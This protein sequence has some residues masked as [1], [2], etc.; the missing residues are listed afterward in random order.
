MRCFKFSSPRQKIHLVFLSWPPFQD[1]SPWRESKPFLGIVGKG[2]QT[3]AEWDVEAWKGVQSYIKCWGTSPQF[4][5]ECFSLLPC[6]LTNPHVSSDPAISKCW[7]W[8]PTMTVSDKGS[9]LN[10]VYAIWKEGLT[11]QCV[12]LNFSTYLKS[13]TEQRGFFYKNSEC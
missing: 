13:N 3:Q 7:P 2:A 8:Q 6:L 4:I 12:S 1:K 5:W 10:A 9:H 11:F